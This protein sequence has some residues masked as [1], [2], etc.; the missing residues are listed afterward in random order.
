MSEKFTF[1]SV[2]NSKR[3][4]NFILIIICIA[5]GYILKQTKSIHPDAH[6]GI[7]TWILYFALPAVSFK[8]LP[9][10]DWNRDL[11]VPVMSP[12]IVLLGSMIFFRIYCWRMH[13]SARTESTLTMVSGFSNTSFVGFPLVAAFYGEEYMSI[14]IICDQATFFLLSTLGVYLATKGS[15]DSEAKL[16]LGYIIRRLFTFPPFLGCIAALILPRFIDLTA[17]EPVFDKLGATVSPLALFSV[18][19]QLQFKGWK[20]QLSQISY[21]LFYKLLIAPA[22]VLIFVLLTGA[23]KE[24]G[25][26]TIFE[27]AMPTLVSTSIVIEQFRLN[28]K[29]ANIIIGFSIIIALLTAGIWSAV[30]H[31]FLHF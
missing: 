16:N 13:Y 24:I 2:L 29:I 1:V 6:K 25:A 26:V 7:N 9:H 31:Y 4:A 22:L 14:A 27:M 18:G 21:S 19:L 30:I 11:I 15:A 5:A 12:L 8:Y 28:S 20:K 23:K 10:I 17:I 3:V